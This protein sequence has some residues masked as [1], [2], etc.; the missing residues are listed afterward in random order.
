MNIPARAYQFAQTI[1]QEYLDNQGVA[2]S[3]K[4]EFIA[5]QLLHQQNQLS[6][7]HRQAILSGN[8]QRQ[9]TAFIQLQAK[10]LGID[11]G[12]LDGFWGPQTDYAFRALEHLKEHG[13]MPPLWRDFVAPASNPN[14]WPGSTESELIAF[15]G[16]PG[17]ETQLTYVNLP[18]EWR[19][20]WDTNT[21]LTRLRC[22]AKVA[23]SVSKVLSGVLS[24]Y[25]QAEIRRLRLDLFGGCY[26]YRRMR[27]GSAWSTHAWG[28]ALD[29][30]PDR[31]QLSWGR[32]RASFA[33]SDYDKWW[34]IWENEG[35]TSLG[36][37]KNYD[38]M[39]VQATR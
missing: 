17:E 30:D 33:K 19:L 12:L 26:N 6:P 22:H 18:Y 37:T 29:F 13:Y 5:Q 15:Y 21:K 25:G 14:N 23:D 32:D 4:E 20:A 2:F 36:R 38:W 34:E 11:S 39:H 3:S 27:G 31:N 8:S 35:W 28:I 9:L 7:D 1:Y 24:H 16:Q 10:N